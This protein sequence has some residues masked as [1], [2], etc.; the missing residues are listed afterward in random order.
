VQIAAAPSKSAWV[1]KREKAMFSKRT[2]EAPEFSKDAAISRRNALIGA[3]A[4]LGAASIPAQAAPAVPSASGAKPTLSP[5]QTLAEL[6]AGNARFVAGAPVAHEHDLEIIRARAAEGQWPIAGVL[7]CADSRVPVEMVFDEPIG[8]LFVTRVAGN[9]ATPE[10]IASL[11]YGVAVLGIKALVVMGHSSCGAV[12]AAMQNAEVPGQISVLFPAL[13]P[14]IYLAKSSE[15][16]TV[17]GV[18]ATTQ[19]G[20]LVNAST[21]IEQ[22]VRAGTLKVVPALYNVVSGK[23]ELMPA[24]EA[25]RAT[26]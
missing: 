15:P 8:R 20:T 7:S 17:A 19:A 26:K 2:E 13:L 14:S 3:A 1:G 22:A 18:N 11:E 24:P 12:K 25:I 10:I 9:V 21:V 6:M 4:A 23:V 16:D 5:D